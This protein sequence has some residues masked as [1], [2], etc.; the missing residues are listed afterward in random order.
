[1]IQHIDARDLARLQ[2][3]AEAEGRQCVV[4]AVIINGRQQAFV[5]KR[6]ANRHLFPN[7]WDLIGGH[8]EAGERLAEA[9]QREIREETGWELSHILRLICIS[10]WEVTQDDKRRELDFLVQ[11]SGD[12][13]HPQLEWTKN[14]E[15]CWIGLNDLELLQEG[16]QPEDTFTYNVVKQGL[17]GGA[18][19]V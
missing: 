12:L 18:R 4:G 9:L 8:V 17:E 1:M 3:Q 6:A 14:S 19:D 10:D 5:Q 7:C 16:R 11:V 15:F 2:A 13:E